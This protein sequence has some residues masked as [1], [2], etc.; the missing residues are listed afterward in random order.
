[1]YKIYQ[2]GRHFD[3]MFPGVNANP[4]WEEQAAES[5]GPILELACGTGSISIPLARAGYEVTGLELSPAM[6]TEA[7]SRSSREGLKLQWIEGDMRDF[8]LGTRFPLIILTAN[9][10]CHLLDLASVEACLACVRRHLAHDGRFIVTVFVPNQALLLRRSEEHEP[11]AEYEDPDGHGQ[12]AVTHSYTYEPDTQ[13]KRITT[14]HRVGDAS[15]ETAGS[16]DMRMFYPQELD[17]LLKYNGLS[18]VDKWGD[19]QRRP[20]GPDSGLQ[21]VV[22]QQDRIAGT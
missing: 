1:M 16:L 4:F 3:R 14:W 21:V 10:L 18:I 13:I 12:I 22:C 7:R 2:D 6:L 20:F 15:E 9:A 5:G 11:F 19:L 17:A 8:D